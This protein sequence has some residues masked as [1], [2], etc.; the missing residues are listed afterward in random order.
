MSYNDDIKWLIESL[1]QLTYP[2]PDTAIK[3]II[4][5]INFVITY[6]KFFH[7]RL[8]FSLFLRAAKT[9]RGRLD[10]CILISGT[11]WFGACPASPAQE[12]TSNSVSWLTAS[13]LSQRESVFQAHVCFQK[14]K[15]KNAGDY[16]LTRNR[17]GSNL[18]HIHPPP[19]PP[20]ALKFSELFLFRCCCFWLEYFSRRHNGLKVHWRKFPSCN[21]LRMFTLKLLCSD[22]L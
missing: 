10:S 16:L 17:A 7:H 5:Y 20:P 14:K 9:A 11:T 4:R 1:N 12:V 8:C 21:A 2:H 15:K 22:Y 6:S 18:P 13:I 3:V 19:P